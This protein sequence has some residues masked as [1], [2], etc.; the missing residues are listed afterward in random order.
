M[1]ALRVVA[2]AVL[3]TVFSTLA[4]SQEKK[5]GVVPTDQLKKVIP[6]DFFFDG[7]VAPVQLRNSVAIRTQSGKIVEAGLVDTSGYSAN[8]AQKYQ[9]FFVTETKV[10]IEGTPVTPGAYGFGFGADG[11]F[12]IMDLGQNEIATPSYQNDADLKRAVPLMVVPQGNT[13]RLYTGKKY[14]TIE[15]Q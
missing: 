3:V 9:G 11:K 5:A 6:T 15:V 10:T 4:L 13:Y 14:V 8:I 12:R 2:T 7:Q 1:K